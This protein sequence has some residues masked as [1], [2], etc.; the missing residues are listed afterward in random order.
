MSELAEGK[1]R[2]MITI[3]HDL[4]A[5]IDENIKFKRFAN[6]SHGFEYAI[7]RLRQRHP[8]YPAVSTIAKPPGWDFLGETDVEMY[9]FPYIYWF[10]GNQIHVQLETDKSQQVMRV[11]IYGERPDKSWYDLESGKIDIKS[12]R[13]IGDSMFA[14][15]RWPCDFEDFANMLKKHA[16]DISGQAAPTEKK[17]SKIDEIR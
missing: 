3:D 15:E 7:A 11:E 4:L 14:L 2:V 1:E 9:P 16:E 12:R 17:A 6:R 5:W 8:S 10:H 13:C